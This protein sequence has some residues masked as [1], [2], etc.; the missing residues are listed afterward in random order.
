[1]SE[2]GSL[3]L[4][5]V[6]PNKESITFAKRSKRAKAA[7][8]HHHSSGQ[9]PIPHDQYAIV[10]I[11]KYRKTSRIPRCLIAATEHGVGE[12]GVPTG[13]VNALLPRRLQSVMSECENGSER[14]KWANQILGLLEG[15]AEG[16]G[17]H[18]GCARLRRLLLRRLLLY[19]LLAAANKTHFPL[20][21]VFW[22]FPIMQRSCLTT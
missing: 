22:C 20:G 19:Q 4:A 15:R 13:R 1:M 11:N 18:R 3:L 17:A 6:Y 10:K 14:L 21:W 5:P 8:A 2:G 12:G 7:A 9:S 16:L